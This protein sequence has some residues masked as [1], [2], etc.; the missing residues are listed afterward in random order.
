MCRLR[1]VCYMDFGG[2][3]RGLRGGDGQLGQV[4]SAAN[5]EEL[6]EVADRR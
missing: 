4:R 6:L 1:W 2:C 5:T 3:S